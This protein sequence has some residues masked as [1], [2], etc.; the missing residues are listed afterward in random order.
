MRARQSRTTHGSAPHGAYENETMNLSKAPSL[1]TPKSP[2]TGPARR[3]TIQSGQNEA[4]MTGEVRNSPSPTKARR[5]SASNDSGAYA[6]FGG[7]VYTAWNRSI[8][9]TK[10]QP[11]GSTNSTR[12]GLCPSA[13]LSR[14]DRILAG[15]EREPAS[16]KEFRDFYDE[17]VLHRAIAAKRTNQKAL[18]A[19]LAEKALAKRCGNKRKAART[20]DRGEDRS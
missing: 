7:S 8:R 20:L 6:A 3:A 17:M 16:L 9:K 18:A 4:S 1:E 19:H 13:S 10:V 15:I 12:Q 2:Q 14:F 5:E 11:S